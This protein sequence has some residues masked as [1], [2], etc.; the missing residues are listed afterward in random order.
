MEPH[1]IDLALNKRQPSRPVSSIS[2]SRWSQCDRKM[3]MTF[4]MASLRYVEPRTL[5]TFDI[6]HAL[7]ECMVRWLQESGAKIG[8]REARLV[9]RYGTTLGKID[10]I[11]VIDGQFYLLEMKTANSRRFKEWLKKG[12]PDNYF[13]QVQLYMHHS[14][15]LS[16]K[17]NQLTKALVVVVNK[18]TS[19]IHTEIVEYDKVY[20]TFQTERVENLIATDAYPVPTRDWS[21]RFCDHRAVCEGEV[22]PEITCGTC[23]HVTVKDGKMT[24]PHGD[25]PCSMHVFHPQMMEEAGFKMVGVD[26]A[27]GQ[28]EYENFCMGAGTHPD[29][30]VFNSFEMKQALDDGLIDDKIYL[31]IAKSFNAS[32]I[33]V[34]DTPEEAPF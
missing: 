3:W 32:P 6:G 31:A 7:E 20:S 15:Q 5:R 28:V 2:A 12:M 25:S 8:K 18:D 26:P 19:E 14:G 16:A 4:R 11:A 1:D 33:A 9:N 22:L 30:P 29:K 21:C 13:A 23:A 34:E 17:G 24:C 27:K 10:G